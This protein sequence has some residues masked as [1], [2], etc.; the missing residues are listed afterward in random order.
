[1]AYLDDGKT[2]GTQVAAQLLYLAEGNPAKTA[3]PDECAV[4]T[5]LCAR[6]LFNQLD[7]YQRT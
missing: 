4:C 6:W 2:S 1:M 3:F 7:R 5:W